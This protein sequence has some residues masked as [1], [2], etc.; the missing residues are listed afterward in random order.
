MLTLETQE[1]CRVTNIIIHAGFF[2]IRNE[3]VFH[4]MVVNLLV[5][6]LPRIIQMEQNNTEIEAAPFITE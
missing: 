2:F 3:K 1:T 6:N 4:R 5:R